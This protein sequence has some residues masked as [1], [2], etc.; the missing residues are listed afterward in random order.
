MEFTLTLDQLKRAM[1]RLERE[2]DEAESYLAPLNAVLRD[3]EINTP[4]RVACFLAQIGHESADLKYWEEIWGPTAQ[5]KKYDPPFGLAV[6]LGN[7][8]VGDGR[9]YKGR[10]PIQLTGRANYQR[11]G[12][13]IGVDL[14]NNPGLV[15]KPRYG[16]QVAGVFWSENG[17]NELADATETGGV[18]AFAKLTKRINGGLNGLDDRAKRWQLAKRVLE[19]V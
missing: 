10:G 6:R 3:F 4:V 11:V 12:E 1:P 5:Q 2:P 7:T 19:I 17:C 16:F 9:R 13:K 15:A 8:H 14:E 18:E